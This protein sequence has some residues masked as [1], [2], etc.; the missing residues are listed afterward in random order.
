MGACAWGG[1]GSAGERSDVSC[2][3]GCVCYGSEWGRRGV[4]ARGSG[5]GPGEVL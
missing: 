1:S 3:A 2:E 5:A 4:E